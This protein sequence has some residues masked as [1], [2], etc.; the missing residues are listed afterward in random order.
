MQIG[1]DS[2]RNDTRARRDVEEMGRKEERA[3]RSPV[4]HRRTIAQHPIHGNQPKRCI[5]L[6][7]LEEEGERKKRSRASRW[8]AAPSVLRV[9]RIRLL[10]VAQ[11][12]KVLM[13]QEWRRKV[14]KRR[15]ER[16]GEPR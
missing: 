8:R 9:A 3:K 6:R 15:E 5:R 11:I 16:L 12:L 10:C 13:P 7:K 4:Q 1:F 2:A 14:P